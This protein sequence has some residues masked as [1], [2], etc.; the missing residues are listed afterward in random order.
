MRQSMPLIKLFTRSQSGLQ[1]RI[2]PFPNLVYMLFSYWN[3]RDVASL[4]KNIPPYCVTFVCADRNSKTYKIGKKK[5]HHMSD[6]T[7]Q[8]IAIIT[9][10]CAK[11]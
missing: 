1:H 4:Q 5:G 8:R 10:G 11:C 7:A 3:H 6:N 2:W 9:G